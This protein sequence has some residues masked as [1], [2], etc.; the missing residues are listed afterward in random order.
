M[1]NYKYHTWMTE[2][3]NLIQKEI[4]HNIFSYYIRQIFKVISCFI[5]LS[6]FLRF[7][8]WNFN[9]EN[10]PIKNTENKFHITRIGLPTLES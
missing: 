10:F 6:H 5:N 4:S 2:C 9:K 7:A 8:C 1:F 3:V